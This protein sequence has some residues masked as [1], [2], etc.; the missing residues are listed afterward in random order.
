MSSNL[1]V[2]CMPSVV[3]DDLR[4]AGAPF[5]IDAGSQVDREL[6]TGSHVFIVTEGIASKF[7]YNAS[8]RISEVGM[9]GREAMFPLSGLLQVTGTPHLVLAQVGP[10]G[11]R[12]LRTKDFHA[13][14]ADS[15]DARELTNKYIYSFITQISTNL[16]TSEQNPVTA[17]IAR[18]LLMCH[19]RIDDDVINVTH[20]ALADM[21]FAHRPTVTRTLSELREQGL[22]ETSRAQVHIQSRAGLVAV[23]NGTYG[24]AARYY[25][26][27]IC[28]FG[29]GLS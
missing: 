13:I 29:K 25:D 18:W 20:D 10:F 4:G 22:I 1:L 9:V 3:G 27:Q 14:L 2:L 11:G 5:S 28:A 16:M 7:L 24:V 12:V 6:L 8:G 17:R 23:T 15:A 26:E 21:S 19:D